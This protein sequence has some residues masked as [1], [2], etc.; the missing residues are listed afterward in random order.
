ME[1]FAKV[2]HTDIAFVR[3][4]RDFTKTEVQNVIGKVKGKHVIIYD[5]MTRSGGTLIKAADAYM[6][7]GALSVTAVISHLALNDEAVVEK[8]KKVCNGRK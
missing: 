7:R 4:T 5:D 8:L 6:E 2:Y 3:K 1:A